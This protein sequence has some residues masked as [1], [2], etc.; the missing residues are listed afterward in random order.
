MVGV[1]LLC[2]GLLYYYIL[3]GLIYVLQKANDYSLRE[4]K[5]QL[6]LHVRLQI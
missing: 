1:L 6:L 2:I 3:Q 5:I 4:I